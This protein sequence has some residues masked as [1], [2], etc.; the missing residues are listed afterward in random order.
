MN[1]VAPSVIATGDWLYLAPA[2]QAYVLPA[3]GI[4]SANAIPGGADPVWQS[5]ALG[6]VKEPSVDKR[7]S[8]AAKIKAPIPG[9]GIV[10]TQNVLHTEHELMM[11]VTMN[12]ISRTALAGFYRTPLIALPQTSFTPFSGPA[13]LQGWLKRQRYDAANGLWII[14]EWWVD[15]D[16]TD[17]AKG[18]NNIIQPKFT[19]EWLYSPLAASAI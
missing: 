3:P 4:V 13:S 16:V 7:T 15:V 8:K 17:L 6:T 18:D 12:E 14:D 11:E 19:F 5:Y 1:Q 9:T 10:V 2:G